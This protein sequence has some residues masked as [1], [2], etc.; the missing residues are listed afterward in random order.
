MPLGNLF[1]PIFCKLFL[2]FSLN[3]QITSLL[4][5][6][7]FLQFTWSDVSKTPNQ[8]GSQLTLVDPLNWIEDLVQLWKID[9]FFPQST[10]YSHLLNTR[11]ELTR[12]KSPILKSW[13]DLL[14][15]EI[16]SSIKFN[17]WE[18]KI[19]VASLSLIMGLPQIQIPWVQGSDPRPKGN[20]WILLSKVFAKKD[21]PVFWGPKIPTITI[22]SIKP[23]FRLDFQK[24]LC[25]IQ[26]L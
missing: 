25:Q 13:F 10:S 16:E 17:P 9:F 11:T 15:P 21:F 19:I 26:I 3:Q 6:K 1:F 2:N 5:S 12:N 24:I 20:P 23:F 4:I 8:G 22:L 7:S 14:S 18:S